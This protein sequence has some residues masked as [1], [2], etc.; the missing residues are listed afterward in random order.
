MKPIF[1]ISF[2]TKEFLPIL[3]KGKVLASLGK[4]NRSKESI[5]LE[6]INSVASFGVVGAEYH[7]NANGIANCAV[8]IPLNVWEGLRRVPPS[9]GSVSIILS[10]ERL[11][12]NGVNSKAE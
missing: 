7:L 6:F 5:R 1:D 10:D 9:G 8:L 12:I 4:R 3:K 11:K 2:D